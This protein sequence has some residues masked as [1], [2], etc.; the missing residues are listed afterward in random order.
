MIKQKNLSN[1]VVFH[2]RGLHVSSRIFKPREDRI[3]RKDSDELD[4]VVQRQHALLEIVQLDDDRL[5]RRRRMNAF[6][7]RFLLSRIVRSE[8]D[9]HDIWF[10]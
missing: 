7:S 1:E 2:G 9:N 6:G 4:G 8:T 3:H 10:E 5:T